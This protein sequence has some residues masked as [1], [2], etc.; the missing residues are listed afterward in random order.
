MPLPSWRGFFCKVRK[1][2]AMEFQHYDFV[3]CFTLDELVCL[4]VGI[5]PSELKNASPRDLKQYKIIRQEALF[6]AVCAHTEGLLT[7]SR[8]G[9]RLDMRRGLLYPTRVI[10]NIPGDSEELRH[11]EQ[12]FGYNCN[13]LLPEG[14]EEWEFPREVI[15]EWLATRPAFKPAYDFSRKSGLFME[16]PLAPGPLAATQENAALREALAQSESARAVLE[17]QM[18][19]M[20][21][22]RSTAPQELRPTHQR[23]DDLAGKLHEASQT[24]AKFHEGWPWDLHETELLRHM[25]AAAERFWVRYDPSDST[26][27]PTNE[28]VSTWLQGRG[29]SKRTADTMATILRADGLPTGPR[30]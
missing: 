19:S 8:R 7:K 1:G 18:G 29:V 2:C 14:S 9:T 26:T 6:S 24:A 17:A 15:A 3:R 11:W 16:S 12:H 10:G 27:A 20:K 30:T 13:D 28:A 21:T 23:A 22:T 25:A 5:E 4:C